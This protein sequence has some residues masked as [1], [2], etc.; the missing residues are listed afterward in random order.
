[1][2]PLLF[3]VLAV[4]ATLEISDEPMLRLWAHYNNYI[5]GGKNITLNVSL[6]DLLT[7]G[8][9]N[10]V[11]HVDAER[12]T[13]ILYKNPNFDGDYKIINEGESLNYVQV[14]SAWFIGKTCINYGISYRGADIR[15]IK[16][17]PTLE[18]C[19]IEC[20][21]DSTCVSVSH[22]PTTGNCWL[23]SQPYGNQKLIKAEVNSVN[24]ECLRKEVQDDLK[25]RCVMKDFDFHGADIKVSG[26]SNIPTIEDCVLLCHNTPNCKSVSHSSSKQTC[27]LKYSRFGNSPVPRSGVDSADMAC[28]KIPK[29]CL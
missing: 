11:S 16:D 15:V 18:E 24:M 14:S 2:L 17:V 22:T 4:G 7:L 20:Y 26:I 13:W 1:M 6:R 23:K 3:V 25:T 10:T 5:S 28:A 9:N 27:W 8:W 21:E 12:G 19:A 29:I